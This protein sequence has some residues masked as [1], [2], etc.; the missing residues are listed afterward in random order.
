MDNFENA[1]NFVRFK[2]RHWRSNFALTKTVAS[3]SLSNVFAVY[4]IQHSIRRPYNTTHLMIV[5]NK[6]VLT[7]E[8]GSRIR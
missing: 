5:A 7:P 6:L 8:S 4:S 3:F 1:G 2:Y